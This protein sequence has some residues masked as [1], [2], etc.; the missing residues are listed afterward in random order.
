MNCTSPEGKKRGYLYYRCDN[1]RIDVNERNVEKEIMS[2]ILRLV[3][4]DKEC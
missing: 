1:C 2:F 3:E 4:Y